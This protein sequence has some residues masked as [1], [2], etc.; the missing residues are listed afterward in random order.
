MRNVSLFSVSSPLR[1]PVF[2]VA[3]EICAQRKLKAIHPILDVAPRYLNLDITPI[4][5]AQP[6]PLGLCLNEANQSPINNLRQRKAV[7]FSSGPDL[8]LPE[9]VLGDSML[10]SFRA[11]GLTSMVLPPH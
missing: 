5:Q 8:L 1:L 7:G 11:E 2:S 9:L 6:S 10:P 4:P 3:G